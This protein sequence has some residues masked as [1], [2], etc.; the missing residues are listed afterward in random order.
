[1]S[2]LDDLNAGPGRDRRV[3]GLAVAPAAARSPAADLFVGAA[4]AGSALATNPKS[5]VLRPQPAYATIC[6]PGNTASSGWTVVLLHGQQGRQ[7][8][9]ARQLRR[10]LVEG[11]RLVVVRCGL[12]LHR[13]LQRR[14]ARSARPAAPTAS[15]TA[16]AG[17]ARAAPGR[18]RTCDQ[19]RVCCNAFRYG[20]CNTQVKCSGGVHCR[21]VS[22]VAPYKWDLLHDHLA[23]GQ[24][25][26]RAQ[27]AVPARLGGDLPEGTTTW[28]RRAPTSRRPPRP[29]SSSATAVAPTSSTRA[30]RSTDTKT[31]GAHG[32]PNS[33]KSVWRP[34]TAHRGLLGY[35][36]SDRLT[37]RVNGGWVQTYEN[38]AITDSPDTTTKIVYGTAYTQWTGT[39]SE[40]GLL[41]YPTTN[42]IS[43]MTDGGWRQEFQKGVVIDSAST[44]VKTIYGDAFTAWKGTGRETGVL[45]Y[46]TTNRISGMTDGGWRQEF[47][48][49]IVIDSA[50]T[51]T[52]CIYGDALT[53]WV[54]GGR[55]TGELGYPK[56]NRVSGQ[57]RG[58]WHQD[59]QQGELWALDKPFRVL[60]AVLTEWKAQGGAAGSYGYPVTDTTTVDG[61]LTCTFEG[62]TITA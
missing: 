37:G 36:T 25:H 6:G 35:P 1:M 9:P 43:G 21:V 18:R 32:V 59:F 13:R 61:K 51:S 34:S 53:S 8:L 57:V 45:G 3:R 55:E 54:A 48:R 2:T 41:G 62:G 5:Y 52:K 24:P 12:P 31:T 60:G 4:V 19:R 27:R 17:A 30:A 33:V 22:C 58:G 49:G 11:R 10:R 15:A 28:A 16:S 23:G 29:A 42:R 7:R 20:Q 39:G 38:G 44:P 50:S 46:P 40:S 14:R 56:G 26:R 47:Q